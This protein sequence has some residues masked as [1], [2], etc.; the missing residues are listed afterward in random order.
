MRYSA[1]SGLDVCGA[2]YSPAAPGLL[3]QALSGLNLLFLLTFIP[4]R[5]TFAFKLSPFAFTLTLTLTPTLFIHNWRYKISPLQGWMYAGP[6]IPRLRRGLLYQAL[7]GLYVPSSAR[8][9]HTHSHS[10]FCSRVLGI[11]AIAASSSPDAYG[12]ACPDIR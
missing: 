4:L 8:H 11:Y 1:P 7:S 9:T 12:R 10:H 3:Y 6:S 5:L 2:F